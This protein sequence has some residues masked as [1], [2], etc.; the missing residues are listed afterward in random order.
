VPDSSCVGRPAGR[1]GCVIV[2]VEL[3]LFDLED[4]MGALDKASEGSASSDWSVRYFE[5]LRR[6]RAAMA[7]AL[8]TRCRCP[9]CEDPRHGRDVEV[10][11]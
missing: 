1:G 8:V 2:R 3:S 9:Y 10:E 5:V 11:P 6:V 7:A 4:I